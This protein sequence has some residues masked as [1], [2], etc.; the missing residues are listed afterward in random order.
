MDAALIPD[1]PDDI[2][3]V[4]I[5]SCYDAFTRKIMDA[6]WAILPSSATSDDVVFIKGRGDLF[7]RA[8][9]SAASN[10]S[11]SVFSL[12]TKASGGYDSAAVGVNASL[13]FN[14]QTATAS[15]HHEENLNIYCSYAFTGQR[16]ELRKMDADELIKIMTPTFHAKYDAVIKA[17]TLKDYLKAY[18]E[19]AEAFGQGCVTRVFLTAGSA[20]RLTLQ[21]TDDA[22][23]TRQ[24]YGGSA[25]FSAHYGGGYG[26]ASVAVAWAKDQ[27]YADSKTTLEMVLDNVPEDT[28]TAEWVNAQLN[29]FQNQTLSSLTQ[30]AD[31]IKPPDASEHGG[32]PTAPALPHGV[33]DKSREA[34]KTKVDP[35]DKSIDE[36]LRTALMKKDGFDGSWDDYVKEQKKQY[37]SLSPASVINEAAA[38]GKEQV[39]Q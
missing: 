7:I 8:N 16:Q 35:N 15:S 14:M 25:S 19:F 34:G 32:P 20:F 9:A 36:G 30:K 12:D 27:Q 5:G 22:S 6:A 21:R 17:S 1:V 13:E 37:E 31:L 26:G 24:K 18:L 3:G 10:A 39:K 29:N 2:K 33:P 23:A 11:A 28:P 4:R 38:L